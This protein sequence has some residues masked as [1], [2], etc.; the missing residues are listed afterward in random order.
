LKKFKI[1]IDSNCDLPS[2]YVLKNNIPYVSLMCNF[3]GKTFADEFG[4]S[5]D[6]KY[7][8]DEVRKGE[9]PTTS[10]VNSFTFEEAFKKY[11]EQGYDIL[12][13]A[14]S[15]ALSGT[16]NSA[17]VARE[18]VLEQYK[19]I[20]IT[21][22]D[23]K[24]A[25][26]GEGLIVYYA[27]EMMN[28][29]SS[30]EEIANWIEANKLKVIHWF[31]VDDLNHLK[32]GGRVS[33]AS[34]MIGSLLDIKPILQ[35]DEEGR[36]IPISKA[37]GRKKSIKI[38]AQKLKEN[39]VDPENQVIGIS[40]GDCLEDVELLKRLISEEVKV[41]D[42]LIGN[43]GPGVGTHSGPGTLALFFIGKNRNPE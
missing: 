31:T 23:T 42:F 35:V 43:I 11:A 9:M 10:Q 41:K 38:L 15:S 28:N 19:D 22:I 18:A 37:K 27:Y 6:Y 29:G 3:K 26:M 12:Y 34:A 40:H 20:N 2:E 8:Y 1:L 36:L 32:R 17:V 25:S 30:L 5:I 7:F 16:H 21:I 14:F 13:I 39:I 33:A 24:S 4:K